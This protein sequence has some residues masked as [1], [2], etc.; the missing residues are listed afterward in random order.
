MAVISVKKEIAVRLNID[1]QVFD[2]N[3]VDARW[4]RD[5]LNNILKGEDD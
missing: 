5:T 2:L 1:G 3:A 4:L